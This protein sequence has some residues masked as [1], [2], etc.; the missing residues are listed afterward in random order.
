MSLIFLDANIPMYAGRAP[1]RLKRP[2]IAVLGLAEAHPALFITNTE[3]FQEIIHRYV[4]IRRWTVG[5]EVFIEFL[6]LMEERVAPLLRADVEQA[7][8][9]ADQFTQLDAR[10]LVH[11]AIMQRLGITSIVST[12][13]GFDNIPSIQRLDPMLVDDWAHLVTEAP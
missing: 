3:V 9:L 4:S 12:D 7:A 8:A 10:D 6:E 2:C 5:R 11:A 1:D 13:P